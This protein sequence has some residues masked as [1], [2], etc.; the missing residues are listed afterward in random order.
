M[1]HRPSRISKVSLLVALAFLV[2][3]P[4]HTQTAVDPATQI[5]AL[6]PQLTTFAG[7]ASNFQNLANGLVGG[8]PVTL[9]TISADGTMQTVTLAAQSPMTSVEAARALETARQQLIARGIASPTAQQL[10]TALVGGPLTTALGTFNIPGTATGL[11]NPSA[12]TVQPVTA[13][14]FGGST[15]NFQ[16]LTTGL[17]RG[18]PITL[19]ATSPA[20]A[21]QNLTFSVP[22]A[23]LSALEATQTLQL[24]NQLLASQSIANPTPEQIRTAL[25]GGVLNTGTNSVAVQGILQGRGTVST[26][27][28][29][30][31]TS[32]SPTVNTSASRIGITSASP[33][34][35]TSTSPVVGTSV[36]PTVTTSVTP[37]V[38][39][40]ASP[41]VSS[42]APIV[43]PAVNPTATGVTAPAPGV[44]GTAAAGTSTAPASTGASNGPPSPAAQMQGRR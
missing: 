31:G 23:P 37:T 17:T 15:A 10:G 40:S 24:A 28:S 39:T 7:S 3:L 2:A 36:S 20:G 4:G 43:N 18:G 42:T 5:Q 32:S 38:N 19:T 13:A 26:A 29:P 35:T 1:A 8:T 30:V 11:I 25:I 41:V 6:A 27:P 9:S 22:G 44:T 34:V 33:T 12:L 21:V 14:P 16:N